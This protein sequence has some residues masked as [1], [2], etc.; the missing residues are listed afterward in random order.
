MKVTRIYGNSLARSTF[1][2]GNPPQR[3][4]GKDTQPTLPPHHDFCHQNATVFWLAF[5]R[6]YGIMVSCLFC[7]FPWVFLSGRWLLVVGRLGVSMSDLF[8][9]SFSV[10]GFAGSRSAPASV[11]ASAAS[12][13]SLAAAAGVSVWCASA[14]GGV[15]AAVAPLASR[16]FSPSFSGRGA[17]AAR[18]SAFVRALAAVDSVLVAWPGCLPPSAARVSRSWVSCG[19]GSWS[20]VGLC[21]GLGALVFLPSSW[22]GALPSPVPALSGAPVSWSPGALLFPVS[23]PGASWVS[24]SSASGLFGRLSSVPLSLGF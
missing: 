20:E 10:V 18:A 12:A 15:S 11:S 13:A 16:V 5:A 22:S 17:L 3:W 7:C 19:S 9:S 24:F 14:A 4:L 23:P 21:L 2:Y 1:S 6:Q 8:V